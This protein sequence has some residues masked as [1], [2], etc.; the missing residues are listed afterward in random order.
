MSITWH[1][2]CKCCGIITDNPTIMPH[3]EKDAEFRKALKEYDGPVKIEDYSFYNYNYSITCPVC[4]N[5]TRFWRDKP[6][7]TD[8]D[9]N[10]GLEA[11]L[12]SLPSRVI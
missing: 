1:F 11:Y 12:K 8:I 7:P 2:Q 5:V 3:P 10:G 9:E 4:E 6:F